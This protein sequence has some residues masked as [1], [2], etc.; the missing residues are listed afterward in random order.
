M[1]EVHPALGF[2]LLY[3]GNSGGDD[4]PEEEFEGSQWRF[5]DASDSAVG[6][7][8]AWV[9]EPSPSLSP[10][11]KQRVTALL[12]ALEKRQPQPAFEQPGAE[13][14]GRARPAIG[15]LLDDDIAI[16]DE[17][18]AELREL[19]AA[20]VPLLLDEAARVTDP[21]VRARIQ[22]LLSKM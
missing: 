11:L 13:L 17:A 8:A 6:G 12:V 1:E 3:H 15:R 5:G 19:G 18:S 2:V 14:C 9:V 10:W 7:R 16:R 4:I 20:I 22:E 21:E